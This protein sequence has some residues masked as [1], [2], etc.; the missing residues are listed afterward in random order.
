MTAT[1]ETNA[2]RARVIALY[3]PQ[4]H[5][6]P[7]NDEWWGPGFTEWTNV[8]AARP[9]FRG[10]RQP[11]VPG[12]LGYYDLR[13]PEVREAQAELAAD[14]GIEGFCYWHYS[15]GNGRRLLERPFDEV[16]AS[17]RP[18][19]GFCVGWANQSWTGI[20]HGAPDRVLIDQQYPGRDDATAHFDS[21]LTAFEDERYLR[22]DDKPIVYVQSP[23]LIPPELGW[24]ELWRERADFHGLPGLY[25]VGE[26]PGRPTDRGGFD[27][28]VD[29]V[30]PHFPPRR[31]ARRGPRRA[32]YRDVVESYARRDRDGPSHPMILTGWDNTPRSGRDGVVLTGRTPEQ[33]RTHARQ[34]IDE[35][36]TLPPSRRLVFLKSWN[37][38]AEGNQLEPDRADGSV[39]LH[40]LRSELA[41]SS[42]AR[43]GSS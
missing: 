3:L 18:D 15:F 19:F 24:A 9:L 32:T 14:A 5:P 33:F 1:T 36:S 25:L 12:A 10:H 39:Y 37:E 26:R 31:R 42:P 30:S 41:P 8:G 11:V 6:I 29:P 28:W 7:E 2:A 34:S 20:W 38:W 22:V 40:E 4:F 21:L 13:V 43:E 23:A 17:G 16:L 35:V 27:A